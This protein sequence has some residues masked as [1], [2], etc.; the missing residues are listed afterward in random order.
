MVQGIHQ[1]NETQGG[2]Q[3]RKTDPC[4]LYRVNELGTVIFIVYVDYTL[5]IGDKLEFMDKIECIK[6]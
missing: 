5:S 6:K 2:L 1:D 3:K 4:L